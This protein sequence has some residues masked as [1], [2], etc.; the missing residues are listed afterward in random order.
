MS[1]I[2]YELSGFFKSG[3]MI[4]LHSCSIDVN[5]PIFSIVDTVGIS[6]A[7]LLASIIGITSASNI[8]D[9]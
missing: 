5:G 4:E 6:G 1:I 3:L 8:F 7:N 9:S 2:E